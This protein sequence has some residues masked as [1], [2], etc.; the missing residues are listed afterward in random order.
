[1]P[2]RARLRH[3]IS[4]ASI[5]LGE[6]YMDEWWETDA[7]DTTI[8]KIMR[9]NLKQKITGSWRMRALTAKAEQSSG[10]SRKALDYNDGSNLLANAVGLNNIAQIGANL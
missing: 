7:L 5:G 2:N 9:A 6:S 10:A 4:D 8:E 3:L 1:M